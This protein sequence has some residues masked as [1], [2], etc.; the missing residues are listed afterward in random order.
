MREFQYYQR[1]ETAGISLES[2]ADK[3]KDMQDRIGDFQQTGGGPLADFFTNIA[4][5]VGVTIQQF[6]KLSGPEALQ[7]FYNSLEKLEPLPMI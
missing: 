3:M 5:K 1:A 2:F 4:P 6:Q 7:L